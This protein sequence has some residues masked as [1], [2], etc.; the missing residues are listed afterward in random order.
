MACNC[1]CNCK[2]GNDKKDFLTPFPG[3]TPADSTYILG[4]THFTCCNR[5]MAL[6]DT[7]H[8]VKAELTVTPVGTPIYVGTDGNDSY[9]QECLIR[10]T[11]TYCPCGSCSPQTEYIYHRECLPCSSATTPTIT[12]GTVAAS[13]KPI[14]VYVNNGCCGCCQQTKPCT[15]QIAITTSLN[16]TTA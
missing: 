11:V 4:L 13:P 16:V 15:N 7:E 2:N 6:A 3:N 8:P 5:K 14:N 9:C 1:N 10:G 12:V